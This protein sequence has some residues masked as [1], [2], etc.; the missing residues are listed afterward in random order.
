MA[1]GYVGGIAALCIG[2]QILL[3]SCVS[4]YDRTAAF[5]YQNY[6]KCLQGEQPYAKNAIA[7]AQRYSR[8]TP[9]PPLQEACTKD[10]DN[11]MEGLNSDSAH[12]VV[13]VQTGTR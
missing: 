3:V 12:S 11:D 7:Y 1:R 6:Q 10:Y 13:T 5:Y 8:G 2:V 9:P 4:Y